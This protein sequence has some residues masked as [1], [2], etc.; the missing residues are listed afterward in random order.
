[1][2]LIYFF[3]PTGFNFIFSEKVLHNILKLTVN[4]IGISR[5]WMFYFQMLKLFHNSDFYVINH[6]YMLSEYNK[7]TCQ[8]Y[9][10]LTQPHI[11]VITGITHLTYNLF[12]KVAHF[13]RLLLYF[14]KKNIPVLL[15]MIKVC[16]KK[17]EQKFIQEMDLPFL[18][19]RLFL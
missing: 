8:T 11:S 6:G 9:N 12:K 4:Y 5:K 14:T 18:I 2:I 15:L 17:M 3:V 19:F 10:I 13:Y 7:N 16:T 1:M